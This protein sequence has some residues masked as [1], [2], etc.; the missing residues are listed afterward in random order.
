MFVYII[1]RKILLNFVSLNKSRDKKKKSKIRLKGD[2]Q[3]AKIFITNCFFGSEF[4]VRF[5]LKYFDN[6][7]IFL[8][9]K[10]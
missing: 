6:R 8:E 4:Q 2:G 3:Y 9:T 7:H 1:L 5:L 10:F